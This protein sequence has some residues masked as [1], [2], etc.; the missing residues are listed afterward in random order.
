[1]ISRKPAPASRREFLK[2]STAVLG[3]AIAGRLPVPPN[4]HAAG[5]DTLRVGLVGC[6]GRGTGAAGQALNADPNVKLVAMGDAFEDRLQQSLN[7][8]QSDAK[9][10]AKIDVPPERRFAG[11]DAYRQVIAACDV[12]LLCTPPHFRPLHLAAAVE[13]GKHVFCEKPVAVDAP[14][15]RSVLATCE[16][17]KAKNLS[18][19]SGLCLRYFDPFREAVRRIH[20]GDIGEIH[21]L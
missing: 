2:G 1:M 8:L 9:I 6:G 16:R 14:G 12:V 17:V 15:V 3:G 19:V 21:T 13:A 20:A 7:T 5:G 11:F 18:V 4:A 10:A